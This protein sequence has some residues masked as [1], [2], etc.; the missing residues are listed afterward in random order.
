M[1]EDRIMPAQPDRSVASQPSA[2]ALSDHWYLLAYDISAQKGPAGYGGSLSWSWK[3]IFFVSLIGL[4]LGVSLGAFRLSR[5]LGAM[6]PVPDLPAQQQSAVTAPASHSSTTASATVMAASKLPASVTRPMAS[7][8][9]SIAPKEKLTVEEVGRL[10]ARNRR[11]EALITV[12]RQRS[13]ASDKKAAP[14]Q[15]TVIG[16]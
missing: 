11:L 14:E 15:T 1:P 9:A 8:V 16:Q 10:K 5:H 3:R 2:S 13:Q 12:L 7:P 6:Q 4:V